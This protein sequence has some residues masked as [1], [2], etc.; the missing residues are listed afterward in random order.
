MVPVSAAEITLSPD[1]VAKGDTITIGIKNLSDTS[2]FTLLIESSFRVTPGQDFSFRTTDFYIP[3]SLNNGELSA[4]TENTQ[5]T[6][7]RAKKGSTEISVGKKSDA[8]G[9]FTIS[10]TQD[11]PSGKYDYIS[12]DGTTSSDKDTIVAKLQMSG[13]KNGP[14]TSKISFVVTGIEN[15]VIY[16]TA[17]VDSSP[18]LV[19]R[20]TVGSG[21]AAPAPDSSENVFYSVDRKVSLKTSNQ[22]H[23]ELISVQKNDIPSTW[24]QINKSY[25]ALPETQTF[26]PGTTLSFTVPK[27]TG[28]DYAYFIGYYDGSRW[29]P[30]PSWA[31]GN[32]II[33]ATI[34]KAGTYGLMAYKPESTVYPAQTPTSNHAPVSVQKTPKIASIAQFSPSATKTPVGIIPVC[35]ALIAAVFLAGLFRKRD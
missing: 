33:S 35:A 19:K 7:L 20:V 17:L 4:Y 1:Q 12:I 24:I 22:D 16:I 34:N 32:T 27:L 14:D 23:A 3:I 18:V 15:G 31:N 5:K 26:Q 29:S 10:E 13:K 6:T 28:T 8:N 21:L 11:I 9:I 2:T 30:L 25:M